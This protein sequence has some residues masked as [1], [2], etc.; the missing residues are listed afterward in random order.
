MVSQR[1]FTREFK[2]R[3]C[4]AIEGG[5]ISKS[6]A[7][8]DN[9]IGES[10][11]SRWIVQY[12]AKG[13]EAFK[14]DSWRPVVDTPDS[15]IRELEAALGRLHMENDLLRQALSKKTLPPRNGAK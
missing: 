12:R 13:D 15:R 8:R 7:C 14:G 6:K 10:T 11:V 2:L 9:A 1:I 5:E 4:L 3:I